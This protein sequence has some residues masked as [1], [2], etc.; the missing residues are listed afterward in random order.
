VYR[1][2]LSQG[3]FIKSIFPLGGKMGEKTVAVLDGWNLGA[4]ELPL[5][6][7]AGERTIRTTALNRGEEVSNPVTYA[8]DDLSEIVETEP[9]QD[10]AKAPEVALPIVVNGRISKPGDR[11]H[12][13]FEGRAGDPLVAEVIARRLRSPL[14]SLLRLRGPSGKVVA[15]ND[16]AVYKQG[17]LHREFGILTHHCDSYLRAVLPSDGVYTVEVTDAQGRGGGGFAYRLRLGPPRP[18]YALRVTPSNLNVFPGRAGVIRVHVLRKDGFEGEIELKVK[19]APAGFTLQGSVIPKGC[20]QIRMT[21]TP[22]AKGFR[23]PIPVVLE[24]IA[25]L[26][27]RVVRREAVPADNVM[28]AFLWR[29]LVP[30]SQMLV[31]IQGRGSRGP[32][33]V[34]GGSPVRIPRGGSTR[35]RIK[36]PRLPIKEKVEL[37]LSE[38]PKGITLIEG[39]VVAGM[40]E[41]TL[42]ADGKEVDAGF[43]DNLIVEAFIHRSFK[44]PR[45]KK[46]KITRKLWIGTFPAVPVRIVEEEGGGAR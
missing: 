3:P 19:D 37:A 41:F 32:V 25:R 27:D 18:D 29:H 9:N 30:A 43:G 45:N 4:S 22:P 15:W 39:K 8:V 14:D 40:V 1:I 42:V 26:G 16:D 34:L 35:V 6:T 17:H 2:A 44:N 28:Q 7:K 10:P 38:P 31:T 5:N 21:L 46:K 36:I 23:E 20:D 24:G 11:D 33:K 12:F 13:R